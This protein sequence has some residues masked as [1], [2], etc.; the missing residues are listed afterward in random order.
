FVE[1]PQSREELVEIG[2][3]GQVPQLANMLTGGVTP[4]LSAEELEQLGF[5]IAVAPIETLAVCGFAV[6]QLALAMCEQGRVDQLADRMLP[7][8][9]LKHLLGVQDWLAFNRDADA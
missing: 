6:R 9:E 8:A 1:A 5:K 7:S 4:I 3:R 2:R